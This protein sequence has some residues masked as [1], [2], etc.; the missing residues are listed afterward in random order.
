MSYLHGAFLAQDY[1]N[2]VEAVRPIFNIMA[3]QKIAT[4]AKQLFLFIARYDVFD[5]GI[6]FVGSGF[7]FDKDDSTV[8]VYHDKIDLAGFA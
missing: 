7:Y 4:G 6:G 2:D 5:I 1:R 8:I 3:G